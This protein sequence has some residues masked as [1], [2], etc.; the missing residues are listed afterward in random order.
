M[1]NNERGVFQQT[2][3][4]RPYSVFIFKYRWIQV[5]THTH[6]YLN[7][8]KKLEI[9]VFLLNAFMNTS[10]VIVFTFKYWLRCVNFY[11]YSYS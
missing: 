11:L 7:T 8:C 5:L 9:L 10:K 3:L 4:L 6:S 1:L 2:T